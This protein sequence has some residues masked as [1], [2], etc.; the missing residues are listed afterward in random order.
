MTRNERLSLPF[1]QGLIG[2]VGEDPVVAIRANPATIYEQFETLVCVQ[3]FKPAYD[4]LNQLGLPVVAELPPD[5]TA[6]LVIVELTRSKAETLANIAI[7]YSIL[8]P[9]GTLI[10][11]GSKTDGIESVLKAAKKLHPVEGALSKAHGK[12]FWLTKTQ[13]T[14]PEFT[15]WARALTPA[16]N[17]EGYFT[18]AGMFSPEASDAG[19]ALLA[20]QIGGKLKGKGADLGAGWGWLARQALDGNAAI[21]ALALYEAETAA[22]AC[23]RL[24]VT[25]PRAEFHWADVCGLSGP[26]D[27]DFVVMNPPFHQS[28]KAEPELGR[29][30]IH[31]AAK[32]LH[33]KGT[34]WMV[35]NRQLAYEAA[36]TAHFHTW[37]YLEQSP[38]FKCIRATRPKH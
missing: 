38:G 12:V 29:Q 5:Q 4:A 28:R 7:G 8:K 32:L 27:H 19:S 23:A 31:T 36:L 1:D 11:D 18:A 15:D 22:L 20:Q 26:A 14:P 30:F 33:P 9:G 34:L 3:G 16:T 2:A 25:D 17:A 24:N 13:D 10:V 37:E 21:T 6:A 35:A